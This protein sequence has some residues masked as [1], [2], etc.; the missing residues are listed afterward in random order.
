MKIGFE[1][2]LRG[3]ELMI[4]EKYIEGVGEGREEEYSDFN[5]MSVVL[6]VLDSD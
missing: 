2:T 1:M 6:H 4:S 5:I 3:V